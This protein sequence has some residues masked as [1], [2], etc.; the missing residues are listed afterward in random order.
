MSQA[1]IELTLGAM[2]FSGEAEQE[3]LG[4][5]L[6]KILEAA[7]RLAKI[8]TPEAPVATDSSDSGADAGEGGFTESLASYIKANGGE[9]TQVMRFLTTANWLRRRSD[10]NLTTA[11]V[12]KALQDNHQ[13]R[14]SNPADCLNKNVT[15]GYCEKKGDGFF[16][17]PDGLR[18]L[19]S[20]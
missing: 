1:K 14:L 17:T 10:T 11:G 3:W 5:Q 18:A 8:E 4:Q 9:S 12:S 16:I 13:K 7:P 15:K 6:D 20:Q 2:S 19:R